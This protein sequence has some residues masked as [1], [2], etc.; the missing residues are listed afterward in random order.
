MADVAFTLDPRLTAEAHATHELSL[1]TLLLR[2]E[3][4]FPWVVLVPRRAGASELFDLLPADAGQLLMEINRTGAALRA[5]TGCTKINV[6]AFGNMVP[7]LH[8][9]IIARQE[10]DSAWP[11]SAVGVPGTRLPYSSAPAFWPL[12]LRRLSDL[13]RP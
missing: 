1:S 11:G 13:R 12:L 10:S 4:R 7:Q 5:L 8:V 9:H 2:D 3:A 6:A